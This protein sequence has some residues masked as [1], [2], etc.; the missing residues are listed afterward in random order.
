MRKER[1]GHTLQVTI[2][3]NEAFLTLVGDHG[4]EWRD[5]NHFY[6][7][8]SISM[9]RLLREYAQ[10][11]KAAKRGGAVFSPHVLSPS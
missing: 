6:A 7:I 8:A 3:I 10:R 5:R 11:H 9:R 2:L 4:I 1:P